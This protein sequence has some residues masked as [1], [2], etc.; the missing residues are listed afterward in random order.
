MEPLRFSLVKVDPEANGVLDHSK[1]LGSPVVPAGFLDR[2]EFSGS[3]YFIAQVNL[4]E[5]GDRQDLLPQHGFLYFFLDAD[6]LEPKVIYE[7]AE[8]A[9][10]I[11]DINEGF[12]AADFGPTSAQH[13]VFDEKGGHFL[14]GEPDPDL[15]LGSYLEEI[16]EYVTLLQ[17]DSLSLPEG[18]G[19]FQIGTF[20]PYDGYYIFLIKKEDL[21]KLDFSKVRYIDYGS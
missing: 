6:T 7:D 17:I 11:E 19:L 13:F 9:E 21:K 14:F 5:I 20:A 12:D 18:E 1:F 10:M 4:E 3:E 2:H 16:D 15:D 8:P